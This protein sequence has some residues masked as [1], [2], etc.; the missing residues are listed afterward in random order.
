L[1]NSLAAC[2]QPRQF[3]G[4]QHHVQ[5]QRHRTGVT[6]RYHGRYK[7]IS[8]I[9]R[10]ARDSRAISPARCEQS[11][12]ASGSIAA[13]APLVQSSKLTM[14]FYDG[15]ETDSSG[16]RHFC[17]VTTGRSEVGQ[18]PVSDP[19]PPPR[20][21]TPSNHLGARRR[22]LLRSITSIAPFP[23]LEDLAARDLRPLER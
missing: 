8:E 13:P 17:Y 3:S 23:N 7:W 11:Y 20:R 1:V 10:P 2:Q 4:W 16:S 12:T 15:P 9:P 6:V 18:A 14:L 19:G 21:M 22:S 5:T